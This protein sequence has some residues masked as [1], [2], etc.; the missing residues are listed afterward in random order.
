MKEQTRREFIKTSAQ[1]A[2]GVAIGLGTIDDFL[3]AKNSTATGASTAGNNAKSAGSVINLPKG[4]GAV[5]G[6]GESFQPNPFTGTANISVPIATSPGR[7]G[8]GPQLSLQYSSGN[9][10]GPFGMGWSLSVPQISRKTDRGIPKYNDNEMVD[11]TEKDTFLLSGAEDLVL[12]TDIEPILTPE[13]FTITFY[14]PRTE[15]LFA[16][17]EKWVRSSNDAELNDVFWR[18]TTKENK[19]NIYGLTRNASLAHPNAPNKVFQWFLE[20]TYDAKGNYV[21]YHYK[22][23][24]G[25]NVRPS[26]FE[27][28]RKDNDQIWQVYLKS[29]HYGNQNKISGTDYTTLK[30]WLIVPPK[31]ADCF[32]NVVF[33]YGEHGDEDGDKSI[34]TENIYQPFRKDELSEEKEW[35]C[36]IDPFSFYR[37]GFEIR[38]YRRCKRVLMFHNIPDYTE[39]ILVKSTDFNYQQDK[40][41]KQSMMVAVTQ[42]GY[43]RSNFTGDYRSEEYYLNSASPH[44]KS[45]IYHIKSIPPLEFKY[46][47]YQPEKRNFKPIEVENNEFPST[48]LS[49]TNM[50]FVDLFGTALPDLLETTSSGY[51]YQKNVGNGKFTRRNKLKNAPAGVTLDMEG[52]GFGDMNG[53]GQADLLF[54]QGAKWG[55]WE[56]DQKGGW[57]T[58]FKT[59]DIMPSFS[60]SDP[61]IR[62]VD[63][64]GDGSSDILKTED[65]SL[66]WFPCKRGQ[67]W[68][69]PKYT[70]RVHDLEKFP[71]VYFSDERVRLAD[72]T[73]DGL[74]DLVMVHSGRIDYYPNMGYGKFGERVTLENSPHFGANYDPKQLFLVD[75]DG[76]GPADLVYVESDQI[77][78]LFN[79][80]G[81]AFSDEFVI[82]GT[83]RFTNSDSIQFT[84]I[85]GN[86]SNCLVYSTDYTT[87][88]RA[89]Y[90]YLD[91]TGG[92]KPNVLIE[93][94]NNLGATTRATYKPS[95]YFY[96]KDKLK[97][98][99][100]STLPFPVQVLEKLEVIDHV[101][102]TKLVTKYHYRHGYYDGR[103][104]EFRGFAYV[105]QWDTE[106]FGNF[107]KDLDTNE[108]KPTN[109]NKGF[110]VPPIYTKT[111]YHTGA[112]DDEKAY[113]ELKKI[114]GTS[115]KNI[116][117]HNL[118]SSEYYKGD[119]EKAYDLPNSILDTNRIDIN[120]L[121][122]AYRALRGSVLRQEVYADDGTDKE[123]HPYTVTESNFVARLVQPKGKNKHAIFFVHPNESLS[124]HYERNPNDPRIGHEISIK[125]DNYGNVTDKVTIACP[126]R[127]DNNPLLEKEEI[128][129]IYSHSRFINEPENESLYCIGI[130]CES[131][132]YELIGLTLSANKHYFSKNDFNQFLDDTPFEIKEYNFKRT[133]GDTGIYKRRLKWSRTYYKANA[134]ANTTGE[135]RLPLCT[136]ESLM[137]PYAQ[138]Q[139]TFTTVMVEDLFKINNQQ[140]VSIEM[141]EEAGYGRLKNER[142][143]FEP[144]NM[145]WI[146]SGQQTFYDTHFYL[147]HKS[148]DPFNNET[149]IN[150][151][152]HFLL[153]SQTT[154]PIGNITA[155]QNDY[156]T[157][158]P[159]QVTDPNS[160]RTKMVFDALGM[161]AGTA[162]MGK[163]GK[164]EGDNLNEFVADLPYN[165]IIAFLELPNE[166]DAKPFLKNATSRIIYDL[167]RYKRKKDNLQPV[168]A[169]T[170]SREIHMCDLDENEIS[171]V[172]LSIL[173][174]DGFGRE[175]QTKILSEPGKVPKRYTV[176]GKILLDQII[177]L[178]YQI[179]IFRHVG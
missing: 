29:I 31:E 107:E 66:T 3:A 88:G 84:D 95:T 122:E 24:N 136:I 92:I 169:C 59:Y 80:S 121:H 155:A 124:Y 158:Q 118:F 141:L 17:I 105:Q 82:K 83:P 53:N 106:T 137:L 117:F 130:P 36:R 60:L 102:Q 140:L 97:N 44:I 128:K 51:Y 110:H 152:D 50:S 139:A 48:G 123:K 77:R 6:I 35:K 5:K 98:P 8:F 2:A 113:A 18:I 65:R 145:W 73:G 70:K 163:E 89:N 162:I 172:Q 57:K 109:I 34:I 131:K 165:E 25:D 39:P 171:A 4:G 104:R 23:D 28:H 147:P 127:P 64:N 58:R 126:R 26:I 19:S 38:T 49:N 37:S 42:R 154:D 100:L 76:S 61:N 62:L 14:R 56:S 133:E 175:I 168:T 94:D 41:N 96:L 148:V 115:F 99:W 87:P 86:G 103:E 10:N 93:M 67:G 47:E 120:S 91:F 22:P 179:T 149:V 12:R 27:N 174:S 7:S 30:S 142:G 54:H 45:S 153:P 116:D 81:N 135:G 52:V 69:E 157:L 166:D 150:Y 111:W 79:Q 143:E 129:I 112:H 21:Y 144:E 146:P 170:I 43:R 160:N 32:F 161:V 159:K 40:Y 156:Y 11:E 55:F 114:F 63:L 177:N 75:I 46:S 151:D 167:W 132:S 15:G 74:Q 68:D 138:Y 71:D 178:Y 20:L 176:T 173:Y 134:S 13:G 125:V 108:T 85:L 1:G 16:R 164:N 9:G 33:D 72:M 119:K 78:L 90:W 101:S